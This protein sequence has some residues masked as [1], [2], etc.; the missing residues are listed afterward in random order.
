MEE[1][2]SLILPHSASTL[3]SSSRPTL[4]SQLKATAGRQAHSSQLKSK[5]AAACAKNFGWCNNG[6]NRFN[7]DQLWKQ[8][9]K[10]QSPTI[11]GFWSN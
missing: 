10:E 8:V 9:L 3:F 1:M 7:L 4:A 6:L 5:N 11:F 2:K